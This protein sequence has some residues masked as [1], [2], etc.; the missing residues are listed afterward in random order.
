MPGQT[1]GGLCKQPST[2]SKTIYRD[3]KAKVCGPWI[4]LFVSPCW[5]FET[6]L[7]NMQTVIQPTKAVAE[8]ASHLIV[9]AIRTST[10]CSSMCSI[11]GPT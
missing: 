6:L 2:R 7:G 5:Q 1:H 10:G 11:K 3:A 4:Y 9:A 8:H